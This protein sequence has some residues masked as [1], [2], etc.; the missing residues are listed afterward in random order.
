[1]KD[2][3]LD[4]LGSIGRRSSA[5]L[6]G[7]KKEAH[8]NPRTD[9]GVKSSSVAHTVAPTKLTFFESV[10]VPPTPFE[11]SARVRCC[12][13]PAPAHDRL[14]AR[15]AQHFPPASHP[16][17]TLRFLS[18]RGVLVHSAGDDDGEHRADLP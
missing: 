3:K 10:H 14:R 6:D 15:V 7:L 9:E 1:M 18:W 16:S 13:V 12:R 5:R 2:L 17:A 8:A 11:A 4:T